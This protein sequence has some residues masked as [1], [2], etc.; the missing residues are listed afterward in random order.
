MQLALRPPGAEITGNPD[1]AKKVDAWPARLLV[2]GMLGVALG[3][4]QWSA[5]PWLVAAKQAM[6]GWLVDH[7]V[8]WP[9]NE[10]EHWWLLTH[11]PEANDVFT[12]LDG[13]MLLAYIGAET[14]IAGGWV[15]LWLKLS[16]A[17]AALP[18]QRL[19]LALIPFA[20][21]SVF[22]GLS[23]L[24][25]AQLAG[26]G[27]VLRWA[28]GLRMALLVVAALW[29]GQA[30]RGAWQNATGPGRQRGSQWPRF[31]RLRP[32]A[33]S[34]SHGRLRRFMLMANLFS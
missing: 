21:T 7:E 3:A 17:L 26:E 23:L 22:V 15:W 34:F 31:C 2:F 32:G 4:F 16:G 1:N 29:G 27:I 14:L 5:S 20:G 25:T 10:A 18:W 9:L 28:N 6:A 8:W 30:W 19:A 11:Y 13:G 33:R 12:W 24:T